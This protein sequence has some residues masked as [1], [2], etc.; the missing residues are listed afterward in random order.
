[1]VS[2]AI[3]V[4]TLEPVRQFIT[5][6]SDLQSVP[7]RSTFRRQFVAALDG[8][9]DID[10]D[11]FVTGTELGE[12]LFR[13]VTNYSKRSQTPQHGKINDADLDRGDI[14]FKCLSKPL[15][16]IRPATGL[17]SLDSQGLQTLT[18]WARNSAH[19]TTT[20]KHRS[21]GWALVEEKTVTVQGNASWTP[22]LIEVLAGEEVTI[23]C[24]NNQINLG[25]NGYSGPDGV[26]KDDPQRP[27]RECPTGALIARVS[28]QIICLGRTATF[29]STVSGDL[30]LGINESRP[31]D[32]TGSFVVRVRLYQLK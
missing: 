28:G 30:Y 10:C 15:R 31:F 6:G 26:Y 14:I 18:D 12:F 22:A 2:D 7:D 29:T 32:N 4:K 3:S 17:N 23:N 20:P 21:G 8:E 11:G 1:M 27:A 13:T 16:C 19:E 5:A 9:G 24:G 25:P